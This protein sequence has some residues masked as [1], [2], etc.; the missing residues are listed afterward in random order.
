MPIK[1]FKKVR[2]F[3]S[4]TAL[5]V[6]TLLLLWQGLS[7]FVSLPSS[8][9]IQAQA[10]IPKTIPV[11]DTAPEK[12]VQSG[13]P[14]RIT[15]PKLNLDKEVLPGV[16]DTASQSWNVSDIGVHYAEL[17]Q[18]VNDSAGNTLIYAHNNRLAFGRLFILEPGDTVLIET[19]NNLLFT[20]VFNSADDFDPQDT[21]LFTGTDSPTL[22]L[23]TCSGYF[24]EYR[25][26][27]SFSLQSVEKL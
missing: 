18:P 5:Y 14:K 22:L 13:V 7:P 10:E 3:S 27:Y 26:L 12:V 11:T 8:D 21:T 16:Y 9:K 20:Y 25:R 2:Y 15:I 19:A 1:L 24:N 4:V 6:V 23:Q 17:S